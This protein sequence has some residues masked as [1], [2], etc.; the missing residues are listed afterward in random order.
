[1]QTARNQSRPPLLKKSS[2][3]LK[4]PSYQLIYA[5]EN[6]PKCLSTYE[7]IYIS[8]TK[9]KGSNFMTCDLWA[10]I[11][12]N[13]RWKE[14]NLWRF[15][16]YVCRLDIFASSKYFSAFMFMHLKFFPFALLLLLVNRNTELKNIWK[17]LQ[18]SQEKLNDISKKSY[19]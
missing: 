2:N 5:D 6:L 10:S 9:G 13:S 16:P 3:K 15:L 4:L 18:R 1:M 14:V 19:T 17:G 7:H 8:E 11:Y 12:L